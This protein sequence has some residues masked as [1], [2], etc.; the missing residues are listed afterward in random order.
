MITFIRETASKRGQSQEKQAAFRRSKA[1]AIKK[2]ERIF[3][4]RVR[5]EE[6]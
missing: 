4:E 5:H 1:N 6:D 3:M 2:N